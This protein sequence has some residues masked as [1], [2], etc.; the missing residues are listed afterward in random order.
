M[1][2]VYLYTDGSSLGNPGSGGYCGILIYKQSQKIIQGNES[3]TTNNRMELKAVNESLKV[4]KEPCQI[5]LYTDSLYV[6][7]GISQWL[8][9]WIKKDFKKVKNPDLWK[10]Y[11]ALSKIHRIHPHWVKAHNGHQ[12]NEKCDKIAK[13][14]AQQAIQ[15]S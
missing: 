1:K 8:E 3:L 6:C 2:E 4:L 14:Q 11:I 9:N 7:N 13:Q 12:M 15:G 10:E 5:E